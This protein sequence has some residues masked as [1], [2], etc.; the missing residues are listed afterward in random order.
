[1][2]LPDEGDLLHT[3]W[4]A[5][6]PVQSFGC[7]SDSKS[8]RARD[9]TTY[10]YSCTRDVNA[11]QGFIITPNNGGRKSIVTAMRLYP[12]S[13]NL[14]QTPLSYIL[15]GRAD[16]E[17][18][19]VYMFDGEFPGVRAGLPKNV[20]GLVIN[21]TYK[22]GDTNFAYSEVG[23]PNNGDAYLDY[24]IEFTAM[25]GGSSTTYLRFAELE[26]PGHLEASV[27]P[28]LSPSTTPTSEPTDSVS[29]AL[30]VIYLH[31]DD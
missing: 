14:N 25:R 21:S 3:V 2:D 18:P 17:S 6:K 19:W 28:T 12:G 10:K 9:G 20:E 27:S 5:G 16:A 7:L 13:H 4:T 1:M 24:K 23:L 15:S 22:S 11:T 26:L 8:W 29:H 31:H 30:F